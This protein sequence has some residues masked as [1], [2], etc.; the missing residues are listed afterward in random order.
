MSTVQTASQADSVALKCPHCSS[1]LRCSKPS[2]SKRVRCPRCG[3][4]SRLKAKA[5]VEG[6]EETGQ[7][8]KDHSGSDEA[9]FEVPGG[10]HRTWSG[11]RTCPQCSGTMPR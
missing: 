5:P 9:G 11:K 4:L 2:L 7:G 6:A 10:Y 3:S 8:K 1:L